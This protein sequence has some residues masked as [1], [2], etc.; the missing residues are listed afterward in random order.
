MTGRDTWIGGLSV[1]SCM[2]PTGDT[3]RNPGMCPD[4]EWNQR[5]FSSQVGTQ[6]TES[7]QPGCGWVAFDLGSF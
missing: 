2:S 7:C 1:A 5:P 6:S 3:A 4:W